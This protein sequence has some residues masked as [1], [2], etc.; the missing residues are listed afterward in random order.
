MVALG[1]FKTDLDSP[2]AL[3]TCIIPKPNKTVKIVS[4]FRKVSSKLV[5]KSFLIPKIYGII[6]ELEGFKWASILDLNMGYYTIRLDPRSKNMYTIITPWG[7][8]RT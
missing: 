6:Q 3:P 7:D 4:G 5:R 1:I 8:T 2:W